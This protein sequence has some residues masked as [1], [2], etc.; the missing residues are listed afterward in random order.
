M[1]R[2]LGKKCPKCGR[3]RLFDGYVATAE[4]CPSCGLSFAGHQADDA[5]PYITIM[6]VG[7][8]A[9]PLALAMKQLF[10]PPMWFQFALWGP[11][12]LIATFLFLPMAKGALIGLQWANYMH[13]F[14]VGSGIPPAEADLA[15]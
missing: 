8:L 9:I 7:H 3:G 12:I 15:R 10:D 14:S 6:V 2:G 1:F 4:N 5:P 11:V 13:G